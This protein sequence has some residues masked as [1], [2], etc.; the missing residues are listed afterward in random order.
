M[1][2]LIVIAAISVAAIAVAGLTFLRHMKDGLGAS[3]DLKDVYSWG[4]HIQAFFFFGA[5]A[6]G[7]LMFAG[8]TA[9]IGSAY[10]VY[11]PIAVACALGCLAG[12]GI[13]L[14]AD[15]GRPFRSLFLMKPGGNLKSPINW[16]FACFSLCGLIGVIYMLGLVPARLAAVWAVVAA[17]AGFFF[18]MAHTHFLLTRKGELTES[19]FLAL[20]MIIS[21]LWGATGV[22]ALVVF[23]MTSGQ[24]AAL[25]LAPVLLAAT[26][27]AA[28]VAVA[29]AMPSP[30]LK[31]HADALKRAYGPVILLFILFICVAVGSIDRFLLPLIGIAILVLVFNSKAHHLHALQAAPLLPEPFGHFEPKASYTPTKDEWILFAGGTG[32]AAV[33]GMIAWQIMKFIWM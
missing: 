16:D 33:S 23:I 17:V 1:I 18:L 12:G 24:S 6:G 25:S 11:A 19:P 13:L 31:P 2:A 30:G 3:A 29:A 4:L 9:L 22:L 8:F 20:E 5:L 28:C 27:A 21:S 10:V 32:L 26:I 7:L 14:V 15:L